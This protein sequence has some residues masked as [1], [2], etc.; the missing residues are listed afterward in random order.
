MNK[1][2]AWHHTIGIWKR[3]IIGISILPL[4]LIHHLRWAERPE[5]AT[6]QEKKILG[7]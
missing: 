7:K 3:G 2:G 6:L 5:E 4:L 1:R